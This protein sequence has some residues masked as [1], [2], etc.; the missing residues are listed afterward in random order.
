M[1]D[2][3]FDNV[4]RK[5]LA[6]KLLKYKPDLVGITCMFTQTHRSLNLVCAE[7]KTLAPQ[8]PLAVGGVHITNSLT[9]S[10]SEDRLIKDLGAEFYFLYECDVAFRHFAEVVNERKPVISLK[11]VALNINNKLLSFSGR[12]VPKGD[13]LNEIPAHDLMNPIELSKSGKVGSYTYLIPEKT[14]FSTILSNRGCRGQCTFCSV[15]NF[16]GL[17]VRRRSVQSVI[18][19]LLMLSNDFGV[20]HIMWLDDDFFYNQRESMLLLNEIVR[21]NIDITWDCSNGVI[22]TSINNE[23][24]ACATESGCI[25]INIGLESGNK[26]ILKSVKKPVSVEKFLKA[27]E[28]LLKYPQIFTKVFLIIGFP[29]ETYRQLLDTIE[30]TR[31]AK[32]DWHL[33]QH[34]QP[35]PNTQMFGDM[36]DEGLI[37]GEN[38]ESIR[39]S[40]GAYGQVAKKSEKDQ[41]LLSRDFKD[42]FNVKNLDVV[43]PK[44]RLDDIWAYM[45]YHLNYS[46]LLSEN[47]KE[48]LKQKLLHLQHIYKVI[49][50]NDAMAMYFAAYLQKKI[51][52]NT[53]EVLFTMLNETLNKSPQWKK[54]FEEFNLSVV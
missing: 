44:E 54:R 1:E 2:F 23:M 50:P 35:L 32:L 45:N 17:G 15:N 18:G 6:E 40:T 26:D 51:Y 46:P 37:E 10:N 9:D 20:E 39:H 14:R 43:I 8:I 42:A 24:V 12:M 53:N 3:N 11:Q 52:G 34:L 49:A 28:V 16:N 21:K 4:W 48:K 41:D 31:C 5:A 36:L 19:E 22:A 30:V 47:R 38:F 25:G 29:G 33:I 13:N 7:I 27:A